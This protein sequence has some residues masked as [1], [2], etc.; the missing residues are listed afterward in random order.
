MEREL[1]KHVVVTGFRSSSVLQELIPL[2]KKHCNPDEYEQFAKAIASVIAETS[3]EILNP[4][5]Q[6]YP[7][8]KEEVDKKIDKYGKF[9]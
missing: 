2:L 5:F 6:K 3:L 4:I 7:D 1:A 8:L 9:I